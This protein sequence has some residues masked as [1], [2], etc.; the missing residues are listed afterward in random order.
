MRTE[1]I[2][3]LII[4]LVT[5]VCLFLIPVM[6]L[7]TYTYSIKV[8]GFL[9]SVS[10]YNVN[11][12]ILI[13]VNNYLVVPT[14][15][16]VFYQLSSYNLTLGFSSYL[17]FINAYFDG[18]NAISRSTWLD[19]LIGRKGT[20]IDLVIGIAKTYNIPY[21][22][23]EDGVIVGNDI[24]I[25]Q[26]NINHDK[27]E[28]KEIKKMYIIKDSHI[29]LIDTSKGEHD[30]QLFELK[31]GVKRILSDIVEKVGDKINIMYK[32]DYP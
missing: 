12:T 14:E 3:S 26:G 5:L 23:T 24:L 6:G 11:Y 20:Y 2:I 16:G 32:D 28:S 22:K 4:A 10:F 1:S 13:P 30:P 15:N 9:M 29:F 7:S 19:R 31:E 8:M 18:M 17:L 25:T 21:Q 27:L